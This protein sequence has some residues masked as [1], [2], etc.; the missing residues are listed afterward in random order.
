MCTPRTEFTYVRL[1]IVNFHATTL[2]YRL[3]IVVETIDKNTLIILALNLVLNATQF[4][5]VNGVY[6]IAYFVLSAAY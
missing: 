2:Y 6:F 5:I 1:K 4:T 3:D